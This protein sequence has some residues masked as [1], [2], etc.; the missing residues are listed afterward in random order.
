VHTL[1]NN[2]ADAQG[3][4]APAPVEVTAG[5]SGALLEI[6]V[7]DRGPGMDAHQ[8]ATAGLEPRP[9]TRGMG[10]GLFLARRAVERCG[11][12]LDFAERAGGGTI[13]RLRIPLATLQI[14]A[15]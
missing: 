1:A 4:H 8:R 12:A 11:G 7:L 5:V 15:P 2:A 14:Q 6:A 9:G 10:I 3:N 13:A